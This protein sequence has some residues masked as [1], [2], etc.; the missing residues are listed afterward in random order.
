MPLVFFG[1]LTSQS[2]GGQMSA[3][4]HLQ[5]QVLSSSVFGDIFH[6]A[7]I[8]TKTQIIYRNV[9]ASLASVGLHCQKINF[10]D[11]SYVIFQCCLLEA[12]ASYLRTSPADSA[13]ILLLLTECWQLMSIQHACYSP[14][15]L[16]SP[17]TGN[18][19]YELH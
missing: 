6:L 16:M 9:Y 5:L 12:G 11:T 17:C 19:L 1:L 3:A 10:S 15:L 8:Y 4:S 13:Y 18:S 2:S 14:A 7:T